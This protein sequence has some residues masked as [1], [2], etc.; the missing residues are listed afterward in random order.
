MS[1]HETIDFTYEYECRVVAQKLIDE[2]R[3][4]LRT[5]HPERLDIADFDRARVYMQGAR[6]ILDI[7]PE[8]NDK[9]EAK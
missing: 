5:C 3:A 8:R 1:S 2:A 7:V 4:I 6:D 9:T